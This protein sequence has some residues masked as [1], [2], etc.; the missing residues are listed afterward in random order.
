MTRSV[1]HHPAQDS[2]V[3]DCEL[4]RDK[5]SERLNLAKFFQVMIDSMPNPAADLRKKGPINF[6]VNET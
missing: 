2:R 6:G 4:Y 3:I 1:L 5:V